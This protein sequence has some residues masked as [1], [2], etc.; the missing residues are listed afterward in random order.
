MQTSN[1]PAE[2]GTM[3]GAEFP[4]DGTGAAVG[5]ISL[6]APEPDIPGTA[7]ED[8]GDMPGAAAGVTDNP[9]LEKSGAETLQAA[10]RV[11]ALVTFKVT[12]N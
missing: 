3:D 6:V 8:D 4:G 7:A 2:I 11:K 1:D 12:P 9:Q 10:G 5:D